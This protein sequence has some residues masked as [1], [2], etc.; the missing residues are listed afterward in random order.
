MSVWVGEI[1]EGVELGP[2]VSCVSGL[3]AAL[4]PRPAEPGCVGCLGRTAPE[5]RA[6]A[7]LLL[8]AAGRELGEA[9][10]G[11]RHPHNTSA[12]ARTSRPLTPQPPSCTRTACP[13]VVTDKTDLT[14]FICF[15]AFKQCFRQSKSKN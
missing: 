7:A 8:S 9:G 2:D 10:A 11:A 6:G 13:S 3:A 1:V 12:A 15:R 4:S 14:D 5:A